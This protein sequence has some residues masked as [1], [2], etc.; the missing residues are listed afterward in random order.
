[1]FTLGVPTLIVTG[2]A[3]EMDMDRPCASHDTL[4]RVALRWTPDGHRKRSHPK[5]T[6]RRTVERE[7]KDKGWTWG[8]VE[9]QAADRKPVAI[10]G[11]DRMCTYARRGLKKDRV[12]TY[13]LFSSVPL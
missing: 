11:K 2:T 8:H 7:M 10:S 12:E 5:E 13:L 6:W 3:K 4:P 1:M 9:R